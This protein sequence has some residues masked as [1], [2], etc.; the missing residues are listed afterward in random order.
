M[1][2]LAAFGLPAPTSRNS[3]AVCL[4]NSLSQ[5]V[6]LSLEGLPIPVPSSTSHRDGPGP[7]P[8]GTTGQNV[9]LLMQKHNLVSLRLVNDTKF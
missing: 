9:G 4:E 1:W 3:T 6:W 8:P 2:L 5:R 7:G